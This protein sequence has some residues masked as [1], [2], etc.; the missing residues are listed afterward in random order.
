[1]RW[2]SG[3]Q[4]T[5]TK[6][7]PCSALTILRESCPFAHIT[8]ISELK[9]V[10][11]KAISDPSGDTDQAS[12]PSRI[13]R[14]A[15]PSTEATQTLEFSAPNEVACARNLVPSGNQPIGNQPMIL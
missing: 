7:S 11:L 2:L 13:S 5:P 3:D 1:M 10:E 9:A 4:T 14:G 6:S 15:P 12:A 8:Q